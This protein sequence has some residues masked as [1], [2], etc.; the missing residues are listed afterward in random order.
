V[1]KI[2]ELMLRES[3]NTAFKMIENLLGKEYLNSEFKKITEN[4]NADLFNE[5]EVTTP[6]TFASIIENIFF[7]TSMKDQNREK[8]LSYM[9]P[10]SYDEALNP[11]LRENLV[12][13]HKVGISE[14][15]YHN[16]GIVRNEEKNIVLCLM[17]KN[18]TEESFNQVNRNVAEFINSL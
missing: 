1:D 16:C 11:Y 14:G 17:S 8:L 7:K 13:Y 12:F 3:D 10:T 2:V 15:M 4:E 6:K 9:Y 18:F 5:E